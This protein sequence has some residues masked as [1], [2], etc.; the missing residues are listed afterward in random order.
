MNITSIIQQIDSDTV[1][2]TSV[3]QQIDSDTVN[4]TSVIQ[5]IDPDTVN[6]T[7]V[8]EQIEQTRAKTTV[9]GLKSRAN[10]SRGQRSKTETTVEG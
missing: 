7:S 4:I 3:I 10:S 9:E 2:I 1:N 6:I 8:I 5:Q